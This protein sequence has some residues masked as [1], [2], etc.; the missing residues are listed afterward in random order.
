MDDEGW[1]PWL[2]PDQAANLVP[3]A[4]ECKPAP[5]IPKVRHIPEHEVAVQLVEAISGIKES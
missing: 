5:T 3:V 4:I 1:M 2:S